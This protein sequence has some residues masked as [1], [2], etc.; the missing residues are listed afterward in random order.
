MRRWLALVL[1]CLLPLQ[2]SWAAVA[3]Y[4]THEHGRAAQH[5]GHHDEEHPAWSAPSDDG[6]ER[7]AKL[8]H[9]CKHLS[10]FVGLLA[11]ACV[12]ASPSCRAPQ[13]DDAPS[14]YPALPPDRPER[15]Q[16]S[17]PA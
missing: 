7:A 16:W 4:C 6:Q 11:E 9:D 2:A 14:A 10:A 13:P 5:F 15:P 3:D 8:G 1:L 12:S 17:R